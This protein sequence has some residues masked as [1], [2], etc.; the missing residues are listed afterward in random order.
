MQVTCKNPT[1]VTIFGG[2]A[3]VPEASWD[4]LEASWGLLKGLE[5]VCWGYVG[6]MLGYAGGMLAYA[7]VCWGYV[8]Y[9]G[10]SSSQLLPLFLLVGIEE[11]GGRS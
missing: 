11:E 6:G 1:K 8:G 2:P 4:L 5:A 3:G 7:G 9:V 10:V